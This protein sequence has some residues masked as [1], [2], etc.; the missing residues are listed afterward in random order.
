MDTDGKQQTSK[1]ATRFPKFVVGPLVAVAVLA[2]IYGTTRAPS[3]APS[4]APSN[5]TAAPPSA[6]PAA[7]AE[8][9][10]PSITQAFVRKASAEPLSSAAF[11]NAS[12]LPVSLETFR[13]R[14]VL[15]NLWATW[16]LPCRKEMPA[17]DRLQ[18]ALGGPDFEVVALSI[19]RA[20]AGPSKKF[21]DS[22]G[23]AKLALYVDPT[24]KLAN[25]FRA[26]GLPTTILIG[27]D[28]REIGRLLGPAE[29]DAE[30]AKALVKIAVAAK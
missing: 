13:G 16:C 8:S 23:V 2:A 5:V 20:G 24:A 4:S 3:N 1:P 9:A 15:L 21:L 14:V 11:Q 28:G 27:R 12:G 7:G 22:M 30:D 18:A 19:D 17:L 6:A 10:H 25:E 26:V 29:W